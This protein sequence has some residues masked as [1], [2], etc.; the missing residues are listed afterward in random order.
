MKINKLKILIVFW[1][2]Y[3]SC[4]FV[5]TNEIYLADPTILVENKKYYLYGSKS[6]GID[7]TNNGFLVYESENL[8]D[9]NQ[10]GY[11]LKKGDAYGNKGFWSPQ[12]F[13]KGGKYCMVYTANENISIA[14]SESPLGPFRDQFKSHY[15]SEVKQID[16]FIFYDNEKWY[17]Y[18]VK[19]LKDGNQIFV[20]ELNNDLI[21]IKEG[22]TSKCLVADQLWEDLDHMAP[23]NNQGPSVIKIGVVYY[24]FYSANNFKSPKYAVGYATSSTPTGP[25]KKS[26]QNPL[27]DFAKINQN[28]P[29]HGDVFFENN[30]NTLKYILHTHFSNNILRPRKT[31]IVSLSINKEL[32]TIT[33]KPNTFRFLNHTNN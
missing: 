20:S 22:T 4:K 18:H 3:N 27:I 7:S 16:P 8:M 21:S 6:G 14:F 33:L 12:V 23:K 1:F 13:K 10:R 19:R 30:K 11:A 28:G 24:M 2:L 9:W 5:N 15:K 17:L 26:K 32:K 25:W 31:G 29:G